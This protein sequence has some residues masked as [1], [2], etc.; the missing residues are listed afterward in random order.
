MSDTEYSP[1]RFARWLKD[2][3]SESSFKS[4]S[5][6]GNE[7]GYSRSTISS[8]ASAKEQT[9]TGKASRPKRKTVIAL[10][11]ALAKDVNE[12]L[13]IAGHAPIIEDGDE[14][15]NGFWDG[16]Y[17]LSEKDKRLARRQIKAIIRSFHE[18]GHEN[19][20]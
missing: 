10:A 5:E 17:S 12:A 20:K 1:A 18:E 11:E 7:I 2:A 4:F 9:A 15:I 8:L 14:L 6:L 13:L 3:F 16:Y 19:E